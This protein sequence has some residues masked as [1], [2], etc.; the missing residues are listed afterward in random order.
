MA[1][2]KGF[3]I[4]GLLRFVKDKHPGTIDEVLAALPPEIRKHFDH[5]VGASKLYPYEVFTVLLRE[6]DRRFG[7]GDLRYCREVGDYAGQQD[8]T[9]IFKMLLSVLTTDTLLRRS[10]IFWGK[11]SD[12]GEMTHVPCEELKFAV[13]L[14]GFPEI[15]E[16]HC[17]L[18]NGWM[19]RLGLVSKARS[20][21]IKHTVCVHHG[22]QYCQWDGTWTV[23]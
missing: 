14:T 10:Q 15:D 21:D 12:T 6:I 16:A 3:A 2:F 23:A 8:I 7:R 18:L 20:V 4:R 22:G 11:Y 1:N 17:Y 5:P 13:R 19:T 9:G